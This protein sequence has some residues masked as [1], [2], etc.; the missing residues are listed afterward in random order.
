MAIPRVSFEFFPPKTPAALQGL[1]Q[2]ADRLRTFSPEFASVTYGAGGST[3]ETTANTVRSLRASLG[4]DVAPHLT[5]VEATREDTLGIAQSYVDSG[6]RKIVAL[7]G[8]PRDGVS[9]TYK[10]HPDGFAYASD[11]VAGLGTFSDLGSTSLPTQRNIPQ[12]LLWI[13]ILR[14]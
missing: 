9:G 11:L 10:P 5:C 12:H 14:C 3:Q 7:R 8:D 6:V 13:S 1:M 4:L 2:V